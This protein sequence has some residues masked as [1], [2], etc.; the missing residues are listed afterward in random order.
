M[1][2]KEGKTEWWRDKEQ[3]GRRNKRRERGGWEKSRMKGG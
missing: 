2:K 3:N 1:T